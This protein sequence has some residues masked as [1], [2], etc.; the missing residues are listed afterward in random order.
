MTRYVIGDIQG[1]YEEFSALLDKASFEPGP[2]EL[3]VAGDLVNR[4]R[5]N[6]SV[7]RKI[8]GFGQHAKVVL[9]NHDLH[10]LAASVSAR[11]MNRKDTIGDILQAPDREEI[12]HWFRQQ[13]LL[14]QSDNFVM[15]HAGIPHIWS[16]SEAALC[17]K[18][19]ECVLQ[20]EHYGQFLRNMYGNKPN[21]WSSELEG[22]QRLRVIT[23]Y[24]TRMRFVSPDGTEDFSAK[25]G[26]DS[27][28][29]NMQPWFEY[30]RKPEDEA[31]TFLFG[32]WAALQGKTPHPRFVAMDTGCIWGGCLTLKNLDNGK[33]IQ[34][35]C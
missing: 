19:V 3:W 34:I 22:Q 23:N 20:S 26:L 31:Y 2:D 11:P 7:V 30:P 4:G 18:E 10:L 12:L 28:P 15:T 24:F 33:L 1:C 17:A 14:I 21:C 25:E 16:V 6:L 9:G 27:A 29:Q 35:Q 8:M 32:H 13:S 5:D